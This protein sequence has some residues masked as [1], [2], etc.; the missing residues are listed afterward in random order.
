MAKFV[1]MADSSHVY[2]AMTHDGF[3]PKCPQDGLLVEVDDVA[4]E[5][6][7]SAIREDD[8]QL[9][10]TGA[11]EIGLGAL[12][13]DAS[14]SSEATFS[15]AS[16]ASRYQVYSATAAH[17]IWGLKKMSRPDDQYLAISLFDTK[18]ETVF[19]GNVTELFTRYDTPAKTAEALNEAFLTMGNN[20]DLSQPLRYI[21][22]L[23]DGFIAG[24]L[25]KHGGPK[26][27]Q[28]LYHSVLKK[29]GES[30]R[31]PAF[32]SMLMTDGL[33][34]VGSHY[35]NPFRDDG[36]PDLLL[37][38]YVGDLEEE[39]AAE[40]RKMLG[41]CPGHGGRQMFHIAGTK[42]IPLLRN[43][44][45]LASGASGFCPMCCVGA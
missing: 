43:L 23:Y 38:A 20:T 34:T 45:R 21:R 16:S 14:A 1:C 3:C 42:S 15:G 17:G 28:P 4:A 13:L 31:I 36:L 29:N 19:F 32:R 12:F 30:V 10:S 24:D 6:A 27:F 7:L 18:C 33:D 41:F 44:F 11:R 26:G 39:G 5:E 9:H 25:S 22:S 40:L 37:G 2:P 8:S 35:R